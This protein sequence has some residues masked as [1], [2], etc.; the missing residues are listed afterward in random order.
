MSVDNDAAP[1]T[2]VGAELHLAGVH[3]AFQTPTGTVQALDR[4]DLLVK[5]GEFISI[6]G[7]TGCGKS[8][9][10]RVAGGLLEPT[11]GEALIDGRDPEEAKR[12]KRLGYVSQDPALL[13]WRSVRE[14]V[15]LSHAINRQSS[16]LPD[17]DALLSMVGLAGHAHRHPHELSGGMRQR[18]ALARALALRPAL[19]L[20][21]EPFAALDEITREAM[22]YE[23]LAIWDRYR[24]TV[25]FVT[26]SVREAITL[27]D[28]VI[29]MSASPGRVRAD[30]PIPLPRP[31]DAELERRP[32]FLDL[33]DHLRGLLR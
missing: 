9:L 20:M 12:T 25:L 6:I 3:H 33:V 10:L 22:R 31:R 11:G 16:A 15:A 17:T 7:P 24:S 23:L 4:V 19:L 5:P 2:A 29:V 18:V 8:T 32:E 26:H 13:P 14:N 1:S 21:D 30:I 27:S 28:R